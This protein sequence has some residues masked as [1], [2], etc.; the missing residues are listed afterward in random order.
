VGEL[1]RRG[2]SVLI[3]PVTT[4]Y[5]TE[6]AFVA[7]PAGVIVELYRLLTPPRPPWPDEATRR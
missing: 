6:S 5:G 7:G 2:A 3:D 4:D 1:R